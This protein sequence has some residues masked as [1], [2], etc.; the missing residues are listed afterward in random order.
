MK[1]QLKIYKRVIILSLVVLFILSVACGVYM[2]NYSFS[3][4][5][6]SLVLFPVII[7][8]LIFCTY[9]YESS[10]ER[11]LNRVYNELTIQDMP[12]KLPIPAIKIND[13]GNI[14]YANEPAKSLFGNLQNAKLKDTG[15]DVNISTLPLSG[16]TILEIKIADKYYKLYAVSFLDH[17]E[18]SKHRSVYLFFIDTTEMNTYKLKTQQNAP[19]LI[20]IDVDG[21]STM[22]SLTHQSRSS[23]LSALDKHIYAF[24]N[25][26][27][28]VIRSTSAGHY[29]I[30][31]EAMHVDIQRKKRF[32]ILETVRSI[33]PDITITLSIG[34]CTDSSA[35]EAESG[36]MHAL[37]MAAARGGD[38]VVIKNGDNYTF[39][40][41]N[42][43]GI[44]IRSK[45]KSRAFAERLMNYLTKSKD[46]FIMG[47]AGEDADA[48]GAAYAVYAMAKHVNKNAYI[49]LSDKPIA[50]SI[51]NLMK[52]ENVPF[53][54]RKEAVG[55]IKSNSSVIIVDTLRQAAA[56]E[57]KLFEIANSVVAIDHHRKG[58]ESFAYKDLFHEPGASSVCEML[59]EMVQYV[60]TLRI[61]KLQAEILLTG[62]MIDTKQFS[63]GTGPRTYEAAAY[64][65]KQSASPL[66]IK[67]LMQEDLA[68]FEI[69]KKAVETADYLTGGVAIAC[70]PVSSTPDPVLAAK[71]ADELLK[72]KGVNASFTL[73]QSQ[74]DVL[75]SARSLG[76][77][78]VQVIMERLSGGGH[79]TV[80]ASSIKNTT[81][82]KAKKLLLDT[83]TNYLQED[84]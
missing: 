9:K 55:S 19:A 13:K 12:K 36:A 45:V 56:A 52:E 53:L 61:T 54:T 10:S 50:T 37:E 25:E 64:L 81:L 38:Q 83:I 46:V 59:A 82:E 77:I 66:A 63:V 62:I 39:F 2:Y 24:A 69:V 16:L 49:V 15:I 76:N 79:M 70:M 30:F 22:Q 84:Q 57:P 40:G 3:V 35:K 4:A 72:I 41:A 68:T 33:S 58:K 74:K 44:S 48:L 29:I 78:N 8:C 21:D 42:K 17:T 34:I 43:E 71:A 47:H 5:I 73:T 60:P 11:E 1:H 51:I 28:G 32:P 7:F 65:L 20:L 26:L 67:M 18:S 27:A 23:I 14:Q 80:A 75:I 31:T 6:A